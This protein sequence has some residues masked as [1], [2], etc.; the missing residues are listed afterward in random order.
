MDIF[1]EEVRTRLA[2]G[3]FVQSYKTVEEATLHEL[4]QKAGDIDDTAR[5]S[6]ALDAVAF[7]V[8]DPPKWAL[9]TIWLSRRTAT[10]RAH[11]GNQPQDQ[12]GSLLDVVI[13]QL[14]HLEEQHWHEPG[15]N[16][17]VHTQSSEPFERKLSKAIFAA[18]DHYDNRDSVGK[19]NLERRWIAEQ[20]LGW[21]D[22][23][24]P[25][26][27]Y[28]NTDRIARVARMWG[29]LKSNPKR[30]PSDYSA[31]FKLMNDGQ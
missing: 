5:L 19:T 2:S 9:L 26:S 8:D 7:H 24:A 20:D 11:Q 30:V 21:D 27:G 17:D 3:E 6:I 28:R 16:P 1:E 25:I 22:P 10:R 14:L 13:W 15:F 12:I 4:W 29:E 18:L 23:A 31:V